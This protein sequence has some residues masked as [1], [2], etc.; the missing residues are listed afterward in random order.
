VIGRVFAADYA[1]PTPVQL[2]TAVANMGTAYTNSGPTVLT[3][4]NFTPTSGEWVYS[5]SLAVKLTCAS[6]P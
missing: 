1:P 3:P 2:T 4:P 5:F 6:R